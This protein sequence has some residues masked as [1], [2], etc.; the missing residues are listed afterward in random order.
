MKL[1]IAI[2]LVL[3]L[4]LEFSLCKAQQKQADLIL[5]KDFG[6]GEEVFTKE[7]AENSLIYKNAFAYDLLT[8]KG[9][10]RNITELSKDTS[11]SIGNVR[12][13][14]QSNVARNA[15]TIS[16]DA[17]RQFVND[18]ILL[19]G[20]SFSLDS[21]YNTSSERRNKI[22]IYKIHSFVFA[23]NLYFLFFIAP[24]VT[25]STIIDYKGIL[26][27]FSDSGSPSLIPLP[28]YQPSNSIRC[29]NDFD[30]NGE[31]DHAFFSSIHKTITLY[32]IRNNLIMPEKDY[33]LK[34]DDYID[35]YF[36]IN[37]DQSKWFFHF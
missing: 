30:N 16:K 18:A 32:H 33:Y 34:L 1:V 24:I 25:N 4:C 10:L 22:S 31:L 36:T 17:Y 26:L 37:K 20:K 6:Y 28:Y 35:I 14:I 9:S 19:N 11:I 29:I 15:C 7:E 27:K 2:T 13:Y 8:K 21:L 23:K 12:Y 3:M 5:Y